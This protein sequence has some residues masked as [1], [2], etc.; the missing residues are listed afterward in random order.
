M[1]PTPPRCGSG[2]MTHLSYLSI[3]CAQSTTKGW[4]TGTWDIPI[5][6]ENFTYDVV[7]F[8]VIIQWLVCCLMPV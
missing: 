2:E 8:P 5:F 3:F 6:Y 4:Q 1:T 7:F